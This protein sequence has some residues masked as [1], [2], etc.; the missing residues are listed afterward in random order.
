M[1][2]LTEREGVTPRKVWRQTTVAPTTA[3]HR[4]Q[5]SLKGAGT[6]RSKQGQR[7]RN[8][9]VRTTPM[10]FHLHACWKGVPAASP[11]WLTT[12]V[13]DFGAVESKNGLPLIVVCKANEDASLSTDSEEPVLAR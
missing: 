6:N 8:Q 7:C 9:D 5:L 13:Y 4:G 11:A 3:G 1:S 10:V 12:P 2:S